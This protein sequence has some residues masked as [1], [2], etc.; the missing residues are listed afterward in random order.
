ME[1]LYLELQKAHEQQQIALQEAQVMIVC[2]F[3]IM[4][5]KLAYYGFTYRTDKLSFDFVKFPY[6]T[7]MVN[8]IP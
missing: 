1:L 4:N 7:V 6:L 5:L 8:D 3:F 2:L